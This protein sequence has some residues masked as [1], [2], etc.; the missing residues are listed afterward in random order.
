LRGS[1]LSHRLKKNVIP[2]NSESS[3]LS[4]AYLSRWEIVGAG[5]DGVPGD[6]GG[7]SSKLSE[8][9]IMDLDK[10]ILIKFHKN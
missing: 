6:W 7:F 1:W 3:G 4:R 10:F 2:A 9:Y 8:F 5:A